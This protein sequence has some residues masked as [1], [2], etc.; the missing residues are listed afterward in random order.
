MRGEDERGVIALGGQTYELDGIEF[1]RLEEVLPAL[2]AMRQAQGLPAQ[3]KAARAVIAA[4]LGL[5]EEEIAKVQTNVAEILNCVETI[6][7]VSGI[8]AM[9]KMRAAG[10]A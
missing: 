4:A 8:E 6:V 7:R 2:D 10:T 1:Q 9:G 5:E 3:V